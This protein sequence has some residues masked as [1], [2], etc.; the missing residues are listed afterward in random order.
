MRVPVA[1]GCG[2]AL[3]LAAHC[4][5]QAQATANQKPG[6]LTI[7]ERI[8]RGDFESAAP[9]A[10]SPESIDRFYWDLRRRGGAWID[11]EGPGAREWRRRVA[12]LAAL[13]IAAETWQRAA[14][15]DAG[16]KL[17]EW[18][19]A[20]VRRGPRDEFQRV[21][22]LASVSLIH[23]AGDELFLTGRPPSFVTDPLY[24]AAHADHA[25]RQFPGEARFALASLLVDLEA[26]TLANRPGLPPLVANARNPP[27]EVRVRKLVRR[28]A[29][30]Q[31]MR[32]SAEKRHCARQS[33][34]SA[35]AS[36][37]LDDAPAGS[38][39]ADPWR[40][41]AFGDFRFW[42]VYREVLRR[43]VRR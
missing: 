5:V 27:R 35:E 32:A 28:F 38:P 1:V 34:C 40:V 39:A 12:V 6:W 8:E 17:V 30:T 33:S 31:V 29:T 25:R 22:L 10:L 37:L 3:T 42:P 11:A 9:S 41:Y 19:C 24:P 23:G 15:W 16:R 7:L 14:A 36:R 13:E 21:W 20:E 18:G 2:L 26:R 43:E 4:S